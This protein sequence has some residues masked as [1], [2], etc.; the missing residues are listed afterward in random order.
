MVDSL[1]CAWGLTVSGS[2]KGTTT[3]PGSRPCPSRSPEVRVAPRSGP[4]YVDTLTFF[5]PAIIRR[6]SRRFAN[7]VRYTPRRGLRGLPPPP[8]RGLSRRGRLLPEDGPE[9]PRVPR[10]PLAVRARCL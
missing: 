6:F 9:P 2:T 5:S 3:P 4:L 7:S 10:A 1:A 8:D